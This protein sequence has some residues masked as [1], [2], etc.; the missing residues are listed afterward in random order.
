MGNVISRPSNTFAL[1]SADAAAQNAP[2][3][4]LLVGQIL[5]AGSAANGSWHQNISGGD[6]NALFGRS[7]QLAAMV[8]AAKE[9]TDAVQ[10]DAIAID[11]AAGAAR[12]VDI[13]ITGAATESGTLFITVGSERLFR[14]AVGVLSGDTA[15][16]VVGN[17]IAIINANIDCPYTATVSTTNVRMTA[18]NLGA[19]ANDDPIEIEGT[20]AGLTLGAVTESTAGATDPTLTTVLDVIG[21]QRYQGIVWPYP[22]DTA[23]VVALLLSRFNATNDVL[24]GVAFVPSSASFATHTGAGRLLS[25]DYNSQ[26]M[27]Y[28][29]DEATTETGYLGPAVAERSYIK[30]TYFA[31]I[32]ALRLTPGVAITQYVTSAAS[33]DQFGGPALASLPYFNTPIP[34]LPTPKAGRG[35]TESEINQL[36]AL[37]AAV[38][39]QN[40]AGSAAIAGS[41][42]TT[43]KTD[44]AGNDDATWEN[45]NAVDTS[46]NAREYMHLNVRKRF[47]QSRLTTGQVVAGR[48]MANA[49]VIKAYLLELYNDLAGAAF[50][51]V[52][53]GPEAVKFFK[54]N[55][56]VTIDKV[57]GKA[58]I[59]MKLKIIVQLRVIEATVKIDFSSTA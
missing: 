11:D 19:V 35:F 56:K 8:R 17:A 15:A 34:Q 12:V 26:S 4:L 50:T 48:D 58:S 10:V 47:A 18:D 28:V 49:G 40:P 20:V 9:I 55:L 57:Q 27:V 25:S 16:T 52:E 32:R 33:L 24:D 29:V 3:R 46:S 42:P 38:L 36:Q 14:F 1:A 44:P 5:A 54:D 6:E 22:D 7:S 51:L 41:T 31:M 23:P 59:T 21:N 45:L 43:Y 53:D 2:Q 30:A 37:G 13:S 39:G